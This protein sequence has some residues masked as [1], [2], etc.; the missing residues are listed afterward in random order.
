[1]IMICKSQSEISGV[2]L[3]NITYFVVRAICYNAVYNVYRIL[4]M[5][6]TTYTGYTCILF[7]IFSAIIIL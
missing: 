6:Y 7:V 2:C 4:T 3:H 5:R 1:M